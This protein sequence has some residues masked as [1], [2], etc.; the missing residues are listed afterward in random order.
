MSDITLNTWQAAY[1]LASATSDHETDWYNVLQE[2]RRKAYRFSKKYGLQL[3][4]NRHRLEWL[5]CDKINGRCVYEKADIDQWL[6]D[7]LRI[8]PFNAKHTITPSNPLLAK[9]QSFAAKYGVVL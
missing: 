2:N 4:G 1:Y 8:E 9:V 3:K 5:P 6:R 7:E